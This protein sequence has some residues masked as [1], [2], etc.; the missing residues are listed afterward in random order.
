MHINNI[1]TNDKFTIESLKFEKRG[2]I[3][4]KNNIKYKFW[5]EINRIVFLFQVI[6]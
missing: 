2:K 3:Y 6:S 1:F 5:H 4:L